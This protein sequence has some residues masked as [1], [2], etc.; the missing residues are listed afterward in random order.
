MP[1]IDKQNVRGVTHDI[2]DSA[3][4]H[5]DAEQALTD[6]QQARARENIGAAGGAELSAALR[7]LSPLASA[8]PA[9]V[10]TV[11]DAAAMDAERVLADIGYRSAGRTGARVTR[12]GKNLLKI[13]NAT[14]TTGFT[15][16]VGADGGVTVSGTASGATRLP[17]LSTIALPAGSYRLNGCVANSSGVSL[18]LRTIANST[19]VPNSPD[20]GSGSGVITLAE[21]TE[22][23]LVMR[24]PNGVTVN[25]TVYP[26]IRFAG[27][28][29]ATFEPYREAAARD[30][31]FPATVYGG[32]LD[33]TNGVLTSALA[34]DGSAL[35][36]PV[37]YELAPVALPLLRGYNALWADCGD[38][39]LE[40]R[41][42]VA[43][44]LG[45]LVE[46]QG[47]ASLRMSS[48]A[49]LGGLA[50]MGELAQLD[51]ALPQADEEMPVA[52]AAEVDEATE[53]A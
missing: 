43:L 38:V 16:A 20:S 11:D 5:F 7:A 45:K 46:A 28:A 36:D 53:E 9:A 39:T 42:D 34:A 47:A 18:D 27:E 49:Q 21:A 52:D 40:Y 37:V 3:A 17:Q 44:L 6:A 29:D 48:P 12:A 19:Q 14:G 24:V 15:V 26:M 22:L 4:V 1:Y 30:V 35:A 33:L 13:Q 50:Q 10:V 2:R 41:Q 25:M 51:E 31:A 23:K 8:G 32:T